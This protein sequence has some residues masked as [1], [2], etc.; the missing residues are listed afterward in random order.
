MAAKR[1]A[2]DYGGCAFEKVSPQTDGPSVVNF[3]LDL[4]EAMFMREAW[5]AACAE[6]NSLDR[7]TAGGRNARVRFQVN[8]A[9]GR[10]RLMR[11]SR[12]PS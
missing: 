2:M 1:K 3:E 4:A 6:L 8:F 11:L 10:F 12:R 5:S 7:S 9:R